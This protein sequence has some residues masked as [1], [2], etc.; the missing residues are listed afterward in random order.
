MFTMSMKKKD[1]L[2]SKFKAKTHIFDFKKFCLTTSQKGVILN[3]QIKS[4]TMLCYLKLL[5]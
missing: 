5:N 2:H 3:L 1:I 4:Y